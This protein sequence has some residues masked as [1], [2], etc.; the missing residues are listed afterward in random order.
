MVKEIQALAKEHVCENCGTNWRLEYPVE[1][2]VKV[3]TCQNCGRFKF[4]L[5]S[6][7]NRTAL[8]ENMKAA[9]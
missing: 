2:T 6:A 4:H 8:I 5:E 9:K 7:A 3:L 1:L